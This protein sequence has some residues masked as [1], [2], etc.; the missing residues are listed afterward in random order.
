V[1]CF[2][3][4]LADRTDLGR[5]NFDHSLFAKPTSLGIENLARGANVPQKRR[6]LYLAPF[7]DGVVSFAWRAVCG[8]LFGTLSPYYSANHVLYIGLRFFNLD[9]KKKRS[10]ELI[11]I[12]QLFIFR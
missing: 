12:W 9:P 11:E 10:H 2:V 7:R 1:C 6:S 4:I 8:I 3:Q 5:L